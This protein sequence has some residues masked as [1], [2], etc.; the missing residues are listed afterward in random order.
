M[1][2]IFLLWSEMIVEAYS[3][4]RSVSPQNNKNPTYTLTFFV[5]IQHKKMLSKYFLLI[6]KS[7]V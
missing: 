2:S 7:T 5:V 4:R 6:I 3:E 1:V